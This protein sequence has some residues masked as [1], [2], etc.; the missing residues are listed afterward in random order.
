MKGIKGHRT[1]NGA[2]GVMQISRRRCALQGTCTIEVGKKSLSCF[3]ENRSVMAAVGDV[4][5]VRPVV[6]HAARHT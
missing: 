3:G 1:P 6:Q 4:R 5:R 2:G